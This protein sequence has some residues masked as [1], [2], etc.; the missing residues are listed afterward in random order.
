MKG[1]VLAGLLASCLV[2]GGRSPG[3]AA[4]TDTRPA[5]PA[6]QAAEFLRAGRYAEA[7]KKY[8]EAV[9][10]AA[11]E[12][13]AEHLLAL[14]EAMLKWQAA[15]PTLGQ[16]ERA[17]IFHS[18]RRA[19]HEA[20]R[21]R[22]DY[23]EA[24]RRVVEMAY[25]LA[26]YSDADW[27]RYVRALDGLLSVVPDDHD[28]LFRRARAKARIARSRPEFDGPALDDF[29]KLIQ[30]APKKEVYWVAF[31]AFHRRRNRDDQA[32]KTYAEGLKANPESVLLRVAWTE[33][34]G[35]QGRKD[36]AL[37]LLQDAIGRQPKEA[38]AYL[39]VARYY[40]RDDKIDEAVK[41][42][43][44]GIRAVP[45]GYRMYV[46]L[47]KILAYHTKDLPRT[48]A[49]VLKGLKAIRGDG[50]PQKDLQGE[51]LR[52][53]RAAVLA[54]NDQL[55]D[56]LL[57][58]LKAGG[59]RDK[60]LPRVRQA[61]KKMH[62]VRQDHPSVLKIRGRMAL[63]DDDVVRAERLLR[64][65]YDRQVRFEPRTA[66]LLISLY[67]RMGQLGEAQRIIE[68]FLG[69]SP[70]S[71]GALL[72]LARLKVSYRRY[73]QARRMVDELLKKIPENQEARSLKLILDIV[74]AKTRR[75]PPTVKVLDDYAVK[76]L[77]S[78]ANQMWLEGD[79][80]GAVAFLKDVVLR[81]DDSIGVVTQL[82]K[83]LEQLGE[84]EAA[85]DLYRDA[86]RVF[87]DRPEALLRL[88]LVKE[89]DPD[90]RLSCEVDLVKKDPDPV[91]RALRLAEVYLR[92]GKNQEHEKHLKDAQAKAPNHPLVI[93]QS[94]IYALRKPDF[95]AARKYADA[96]A[97]A[98]LD[99]VRGRMYRA[100]LARAQQKW[101]EA[102]R[103][104]LEALRIRPRFSQA[105]AFL[106]DCYVAAGKYDEARQAYETAHE[107]DPSNVRALRGLVA[108]SE[109]TGNRDAYEH[110]VNM[111]Y[112]F[113]PDSP[114]IRERYLQ[115]R[116][117]RESP[118]KIIRHRE[119]VAKLHPE[120]LVNLGHL[121]ILYERVGQLRSAEKIYH[122]MIKVSNGAPQP[123]RLLVNVLRRAG[124]DAEARRIL[125]DYA[126]SARDKV[127]AY[128]LWGNY[129]EAAGEYRP[130]GTAYEKAVE[131]G[132]E[133]ARG[134]LTLARFA[135][136]RGNWATAVKRQKKYLA[137]FGEQ[138][139]PG[140]ERDLISYLIE[141]DE[142][143]QV[144]ERTSRVLAQ[145]P[146]NMVMLM[147]R[148]KAYLRQGGC[149]RAR[150]VLDR[151][152]SVH[153][154]CSEA[155]M[156][157]AR[158]HLAEGRTA[159]ARED[160]AGA[161]RA[162]VSAATS[163]E[164]AGVYED[165][166]DFPGA[167]AVLQSVLA[168]RPGY[169]PA[170]EA[171]LRL[172]Q[173]HR[174]WSQLAGALARFRKAYPRELFP[175]VAETEMLLR[176]G[177]PERAV[178]LL[179]AAKKVLPETARITVLQMRALVAAGRHDEAI[180]AGEGLRGGRELGASVLAVSGRARAAKKDHAQAEEDFRQALKRAEA[181]EQLDFVVGQVVATH[182]A[183]AAAK[184]AQWLDARPD[185]WQIRLLLAN[186]LLREKQYAPALEHLKKG[187]ALA[188]EGADR[189]KLLRH[190]GLV[191][192]SSGR[193]AESRRSYEAA[194]KIDPKDTVALNNLAW[195]LAGDLKR[196]AEALAHARRAVQLTPHSPH[197]LDTLGFVLKA[198]GRHAEAAKALKRSI[199]L[200]PRP[201]SRLRLGEVY[202]KMGR[203]D[204]A[205]REYWAGWRQVR[206]DRTHPYYGKLRD[207]L[208]RLGTPPAEH[209]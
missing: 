58:R 66:I 26:R 156:C 112:K 118:E 144:E 89:A 53:Y 188:T 44:A 206:K 123:V 170:L 14:G 80:K 208:T 189:F 12:R 152:L 17:E 178:R 51:G 202:E 194:L 155:L 102:I 164:L 192:Y 167:H 108:V 115:L 21:L 35:E 22:P 116:Q 55:C 37:Q 176:R 36:E 67:R 147:L 145:D 136:R 201:G 76:V 74:T 71:P 183:A 111:A 161:R 107:Q 149:V 128:L 113:Q 48:E 169:K 68:R 3:A 25:V 92:A 10:A 174:R 85:A 40:Q 20:V 187:L 94:F 90:R 119:Q 83:W 182:K 135:A 33:L 166:G 200:Q 139:Y 52:K 131:V 191:Y 173:R 199:D 106:G 46:T 120:D 158:V 77:S 168:D 103:L 62:D 117:G 138:A 186:L 5:S 132:P 49:L 177:Q 59:D 28:A 163:L 86:T 101:D 185:D 171:L 7:V 19:F 11:G 78:H 110:W 23:V 198:L 6:E 70:Q 127:A 105:R 109:A 181:G 64:T 104:T 159:L 60:I 179:V 1:M 175:I 91:R 27:V 204:D 87:K 63:A 205:L 98:D 31:A 32:E 72:E 184:L 114:A 73:D 61:L 29:K 153:P 54:L 180:V 81:R 137:K 157:R 197:T 165:M 151:C 65:A 56:V 99:K 134:Y 124:R 43:E 100:R 69:I 88:A 126:G 190:Q 148:G 150:E 130:A 195:V 142:F 79:R 82:M 18:A 141:A 75:I 38:E 129:L 57:D 39:A 93:E 24:H 50:D 162:G 13:K 97:K 41:V 9:S 8:R 140:A 154:G 203:K 95:A 207:A 196:P 96:A 122:H 34:L 193:F 16:A 143:R 133:D 209:Q 4:G 146:G 121:G 30:A 160:L 42:L 45:Q 84:T 172:C 15:D 47:A 2:A 125:V